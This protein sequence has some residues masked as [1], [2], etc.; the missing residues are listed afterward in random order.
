[1]VAMPYAIDGLP[2]VSTHSATC[3]VA[4]R[5]TAAWCTSPRRQPPLKSTSRIGRATRGMPQLCSGT[6]VRSSRSANARWAAGTRSLRRAKSRAWS[7]AVTP[8]SNRPWPTTSR[9][10][11]AARPT[12]SSPASPTTA[13]MARAASLS[14]RRIIAASRARTGLSTCRCVRRYATSSIV[15]TRLADGAPRAMRK[16]R[17]RPAV[18]TTANETTPRRRAAQRRAASRCAAVGAA[19]GAVASE[20]AV[21]GGA[22]GAADCER[23]SATGATSRAASAAIATPRPPTISWRA[24]APGGWPRTRRSPRRGSAPSPGARATRSCP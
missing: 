3:R 1:M 11:P 18:S 6:I 15:L 9:R 22:G 23:P 4:L 21:G 14:E 24:R 12:A 8:V 13:W 20:A 7:A 5:S 17:R 10:I 19:G 16:P 2:V